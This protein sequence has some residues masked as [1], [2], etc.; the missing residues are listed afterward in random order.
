MCGLY[1]ALTCHIFDTPLLW[2]RFIQYLIGKRPGLVNMSLGGLSFSSTLNISQGHLEKRS[3]CV[4]QILI[5]C[6]V[7][8]QDFQLISYVF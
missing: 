4:L 2:Y 8:L 7:V 1:E 5:A 6:F 3:S